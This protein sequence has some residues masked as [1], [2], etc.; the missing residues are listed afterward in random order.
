MPDFLKDVIL[1]CVHWEDA[2]KV[3]G[4]VLL[5]VVD[6]FGLEA[7]WY[8]EGERLGF[9]FILLEIVG[10]FFRRF[11][12]QKRLNSVLSLLILSHYPLLE[13]PITA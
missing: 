13:L 10:R 1:L 12:P 9:E 8:S 7:L 3:E 2:V 4:M 5:G 6:V 11:N